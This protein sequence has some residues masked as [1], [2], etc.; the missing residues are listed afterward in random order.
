MCFGIHHNVTKV[1]V[2]AV[3]NKK[4]Q[5]E[6][7]QE[8]TKETTPQ[9][10]NMNWLSQSLLSAWRCGWKEAWCGAQKGTPN[11]GQMC[12]DVARYKHGRKARWTILNTVGTK[13][14][15]AT[16]VHPGKVT[17]KK[18]NMRQQSADQVSASRRACRTGWNVMQKAL[19]QRNACQETAVAANKAENL[20]IGRAD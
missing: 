13:N 1:L 5:L 4:K 7:S 12:V 11:S 10:L 18:L 8:G 17:G 2:Q 15:P 20:K 9:T 19:P 14:W 16:T 6:R 3:N